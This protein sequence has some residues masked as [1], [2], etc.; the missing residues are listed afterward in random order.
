MWKRSSS[1]QRSQC[2]R[3]RSQSPH[4]GNLGQGG[5]VPAAGL[6]HDDEILDADTPEARVVQTGLDGDD[7]ADFQ[8]DVGLAD[9]REL[10][11]LEPQPVARCRG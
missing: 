5:E 7:V 6:G 3:S 8:D 9:S 1:E 4:D 10:V 2:S 11:D